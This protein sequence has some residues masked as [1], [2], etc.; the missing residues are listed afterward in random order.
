MVAFIPRSNAVK[1]AGK[2]YPT[3][4]DP[5]RVTGALCNQGWGVGLYDLGLRFADID[6]DGRVGS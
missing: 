3:F 6:G 2:P 1:T 5:V 4:N